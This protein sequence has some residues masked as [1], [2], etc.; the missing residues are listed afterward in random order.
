MKRA[1]LVTI[2]LALSCIEPALLPWDQST[3]ADKLPPMAAIAYRQARDLYNRGKFNDAAKRF[4]RTFELSQRAGRPYQ[5]ALKY[6]ALC[7]Q[8]QGDYDR[9]FELFKN[10]CQWDSLS[11]ETADSLNNLG[12][13]AYLRGD[14]DQSRDYLCRAE[15]TL[16][17]AGDVFNSGPGPSAVYINL[18]ILSQSYGDYSRALQS[19]HQARLILDTFPHLMN[20]TRLLQQMGNLER[21]WGDDKQAMEFYRQSLS[22]A[23]KA[24][25]EMYNR[26][27]YVDALIDFANHVGDEGPSSDN[28][29]AILQSALLESRRLG[30]RRLTAR[31]LSAQGDLFFMRGDARSALDCHRKA[32]DE[33]SHLGLKAAEQEILVAMGRDYLALRDF[34]AAS[35]TLQQ[36][37]LS[38][39]TSLPRE[40]AIRL[41]DGLSRSVAGQGDLQSGL[42]YNQIA[43]DALERTDIRIVPELKRISYWSDRHDTYAEGVELLIEMQNDSASFEMS[44]RGRNKTFNDMVLESIRAPASRSGASEQD[45][46]A[47][48]SSLQLQLAGVQE[49]DREKQILDSLARARAE[50]DAITIQNRISETNMDLKAPAIS[51][52]AL[53]RKLDAQGELF[54]EFLL[55]DP[56]SH[57]WVIS[58]DSCKLLTLPGRQ[59]IEGSVRDFL[60]LVS[61]LPVGRDALERWQHTSCEMFQMLF[62]NEASEVARASKLDIAA[63][64]IL[65]SLP[66]ES[67]LASPASAFSFSLGSKEVVYVPSASLWNLEKV[68]PGKKSANEFLAIGFAGPNPTSGSDFSQMLWRRY[69]YL[70]NAEEEARVVGHSLAR[71]K[72]KVLFGKDASEAFLDSADLSRY[73]IIHLASHA[74]VDES[75]PRSSGV[76]LSP[77]QG[78][79]GYLCLDEI[80]QLRL[81]ADLVTLS[82]CRTGQGQIRLGE[83]VLSLARAFME[84]GAHNVV[85]SLWKTDD[86]AS[87]EFMKAFYQ[88]LAKAS[89]P[90]QALREARRAFFHSPIPAYRHPYFWAPFVVT[91]ARR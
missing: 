35:R 59:E 86:E 11:D 38:N 53:K 60:E 57:A 45:Q 69:R 68:K 41:Y 8:Y 74:Y 80:S 3:Q 91:R 7:F 55:S 87:L 63:D 67:L 12:W 29:E 84:A 66:F 83:G 50:L 79:D 58:K 75:D 28:P 10:A 44:E 77:G 1:L 61:T 17:E 56:R 73:R 72:G 33:I 15:K 89:S 5:L 31:V 37:L 71:W 42:R 22:K 51:V 52:E 27:Y 32:L 62:S 25:H 49:S 20:E 65:N 47:R 85:M 6:E 24:Y 16:R 81:N 88:H 34:A 4:Q 21:M 46:L 54:I 9:A 90:A 30:V 36:A 39:P 19:F 48:I 2:F 18:G 70:P 23:D 76:F 14:L 43:L 64:G 13:L 82:G 26:T 40:L 78:Q